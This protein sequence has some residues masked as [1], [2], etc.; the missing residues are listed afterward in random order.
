M[1]VVSLVI[2][3]YARDLFHP[4]GPGHYGMLETKYFRPS[5]TVPGAR[6][7]VFRYYESPVHYNPLSWNCL[8]KGSVTSSMQH[9]LFELCNEAEAARDL[10]A[11]LVVLQGLVLTSHAWTWWTERQSGE[12][13]WAAQRLGSE[14]QIVPSPER[15]E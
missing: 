7:D 1:F 11:V 15:S 3:I 10:V 9:R 12:M 2:I 8:A 4:Y 5:L 6:D 14:E 13:P